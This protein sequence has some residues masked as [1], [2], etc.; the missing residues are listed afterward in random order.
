MQNREAEFAWR[1]AKRRHID[2]AAAIGS[3]TDRRE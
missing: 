1:R 2:D 3:I